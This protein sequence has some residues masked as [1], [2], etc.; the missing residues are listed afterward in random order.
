M[1]KF[2][3]DEV[4]CFWS[5]LRSEGFPDKKWKFWSI[6]LPRSRCTPHVGFVLQVLLPP[7]PLKLSTAP[8]LAV[9]HP[10]PRLGGVTMTLLWRYC[11]CG[12]R[13]Q[14]R[15]PVQRR[16]PFHPVILIGWSSWPYVT[17]CTRLMPTRR[18]ITPTSVI[19]SPEIWWMM[20]GATPAMIRDVHSVDLEGC[21]ESS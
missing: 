1:K 17:M 6:S 19:T 4:G 3:K 16:I 20:L 14:R 10:S 21:W 8:L 15:V 2:E 7:E 11:F 13:E 18:H 5:V 9:Y 12:G